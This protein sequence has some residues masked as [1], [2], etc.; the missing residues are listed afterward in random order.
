MSSAIKHF[1][2]YA[3]AKAAFVPSSAEEHFTNVQELLP[4]LTELQK[5]FVKK[6][7]TLAYSLGLAS[8]ENGGGLLTSG[9]GRASL[10]ITATKGAD[11]LELRLTLTERLTKKVAEVLGDQNFRADYGDQAGQAAI[12]AALPVIAGRKF[13]IHAETNGLF[14]F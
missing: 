5:G 1:Q 11:A 6:G 9:S 12:R 4:Y 8:A 10:Y 13:G 2:Q 3:V 7:Y 14:I